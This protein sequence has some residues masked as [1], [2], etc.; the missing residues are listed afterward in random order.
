MESPTWETT[1]Q[2]L[3]D[4]SSSRVRNKATLETMNVVHVRRS[5]HPFV[6]VVVFSQSS[7]LEASAGGYNN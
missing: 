2:Q 7:I 5:D 3:S 6:V 4:V 1:P